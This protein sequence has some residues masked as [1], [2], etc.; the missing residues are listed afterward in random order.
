MTPVLTTLDKP[1]TETG[2]NRQVSWLGRIDPR[3]RILSAAG[4]A[5]LVVACSGPTAR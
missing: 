1:L 5:V 2:G 3:L 4:F